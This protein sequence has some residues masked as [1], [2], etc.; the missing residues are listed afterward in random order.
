[1][2][3]S[4]ATMNRGDVEIRSGQRGDSTELVGTPDLVIE[5]VSKSSVEKDTEWLAEKY[6]E[7][8]TV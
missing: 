4:H 8:L 5:V 7:V 1:M 2:F 6:Y 3:V